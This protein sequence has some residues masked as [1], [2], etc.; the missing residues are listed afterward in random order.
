MVRADTAVGAPNAAVFVTNKNGVSFQWRSAPGG[1]TTSAK[2]PSVTAPV[3]VKLERHENDFSGFYS[4]DGKKWT[5]IGA[6]QTLVMK[7]AALAGLAATAHNAALSCTAKL[8]SFL[9]KR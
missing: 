4:D 3:W 5:Q 6:T 1:P 2:V 7:K 8:K 9:V